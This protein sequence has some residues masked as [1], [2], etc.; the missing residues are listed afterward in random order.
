MPRDW[1]DDAG[2]LALGKYRGQSVEDVARDDPSYLRW[3]V[4]EVEDVS[5]GDR[6]VIEAALR[7]RGR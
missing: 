6:A 7:Y 5:D 2:R 1:L 4:A 3:V